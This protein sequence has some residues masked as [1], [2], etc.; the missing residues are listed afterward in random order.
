MH[1]NSPNSVGHMFG[2]LVVDRGEGS[3][4]YN[5]ETGKKY[6][7]LAC[8]IGVTNTGHCH[9]RVVKAIQDQASQ[10]MH[11][12]MNLVLHKPMYQLMNK[13][14]ERRVMPH[15]TLDTFFFANSGSE[16]VENA[17]KLAR[18]ATKKRNVIV[19]QGSFHGR[20]IGCLSL[21][22]SKTIYGH[23]FGPFMPNVYVAPFPYC[24]HCKQCDR[25]SGAGETVDSPCCL[26]PIHSLEVLL[27]QQSA[28]E[29]TAAIIIEP[30]LGEGGY[31]PA[32]KAYME[33]LRA[34]CDRHNILLIVDEVQSG[35]GRT[36]K[37]F[38]IEHSGVRPDILVMAKG[39]ASGMPLSAI[40][41]NKKLFENSP[42]GT[43]GG[44]YGGNAVAVAAASATLDV[45]LEENILENVNKRSKQFYGALEQMKRKYENLILDV[46][47]PGLMIGVELKGPYGTANKVSQECLKQ[48]MLVMTTSVFET[49][50]LIP[51]LNITE[52]EA[53]IAI[54]R[55]DRAF[56]T[57][58][59]SL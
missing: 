13:W 20:T 32:P 11:G 33:Q 7:D 31:V 4:L 10:L 57:V 16:A 25:P 38:A 51:P 30:V 22:T 12:Q 53:A 50:R 58:S 48:D 45:I 2:D 28:P 5:D 17:I 3:W 59:A 29:D 23:G 40:A 54:E 1:R 21:T 42:P 41:A 47:G 8:G 39:L 43:F 9:P 6:L 15:S 46:R 24:A 52:Q 35:Y 34:L 55:L 36:G 37:M 27:K 18:A 56:A 44:T 14:I 49:L 19:M 26:A